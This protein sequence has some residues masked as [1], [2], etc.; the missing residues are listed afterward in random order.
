MTIHCTKS[1]MSTKNTKVGPRSGGPPPTPF[2]ET[3]ICD[4]CGNVQVIK[5]TQP[6][7]CTHCH[8]RI[9]RKERTAH[10]VQII[11]R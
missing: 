6:V 7:L 9:F 3:Y 2:E 10:I 5:S 8:G 4:V 1:A 11:A